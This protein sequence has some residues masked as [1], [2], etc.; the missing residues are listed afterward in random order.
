MLVESMAK[1]TSLRNSVHTSWA[2]KKSIPATPR[3]MKLCSRLFFLD[4]RKFNIFGMNKMVLMRKFI[5]FSMSVYLQKRFLTN[6]KYY[7]ETGLWDLSFSHAENLFHAKTT[8]AGAAVSGL[9]AEWNS[10]LLYWG[11]KVASWGPMQCPLTT[12]CLMLSLKTS[13]SWN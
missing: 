3:K 11:G 1:C 13:P 12:V 8:K 6:W 4:S 9:T 5:P 10:F 7:K 2:F